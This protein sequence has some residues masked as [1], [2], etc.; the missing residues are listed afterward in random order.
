MK[1]NFKKSTKGVI[2]ELINDEYWVNQIPDE[3]NRI[4]YLSYFVLNVTRHWFDYKLPK[5]I[6]LINDI[7]KYAF[8]KRGLSYGNYS[9][10]ASQLENGFLPINLAAL[11]KYDV[12]HSAISK[13]QKTLR[14]NEITTENLI[15]SFKRK[16]VEQRLKQIGLIKYEIDK[17][18]S[19]N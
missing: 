2:D 3:L 1:Y 11:L 9:F 12:P 8:N 7:Q 17:I 18:K 6:S 5:W 10:Y 15:A 4:N 16:G 14:V 13:I 19:I